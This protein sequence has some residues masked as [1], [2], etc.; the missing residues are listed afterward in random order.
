M[1]VKC[2]K[3]NK[4]TRQEEYITCRKTCGSNF[5][6][7]CIDIDKAQQVLESTKSLSGWGCCLCK[8]SVITEEKQ[9]LDKLDDTSKNLS[10]FIRDAF[11]E[12]INVMLDHFVA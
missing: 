3:C 10:V 4:I 12:F 2:R 1:G 8:S 6:I 9:I 11:S 5:H 7:G